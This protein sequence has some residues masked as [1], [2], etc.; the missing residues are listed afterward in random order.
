MVLGTWPSERY[1]LAWVTQRLMNRAPEQ[2]HARK[3]AAS[4]A[5]QLANPVG[6]EIQKTIQQL[7]EERDNMFVSSADISLID[8]IYKVD[9][10]PSCSFKFEENYKGEVVY[11]LPKVYAI[12]N[13]VEEEITIAKENDIQ[14]LIYEALPSRIEDGE[15]SYSHEK[16][17]PRTQV[18]DLVNITPKEMAIEGHL[19]ITLEENTNWE[20]R[21]NQKIY[22]S[23]VY[24]SGITRKGTEVTEVIP[25]RYN[26]TFRSTNQWKSVSEVFI[27]Y[28]DETAYLIVDCFPFAQ[29]GILDNRNLV[30]SPDREEKWRY[31]KL[32]TQAWGS[33]FVSEAYTTNNFDIIRQGIE[34][35]DTE[36]EIELLDS[37]GNN[38]SFDCFVMK[39]KTDYMFAVKDDKLYV[40]NTQLPYPEVT[41]LTDESPDVKMDLYS[42]QW[43]YCRADTAN[44]KTRLLDFAT[45]PWRVRWSIE[46]P[47]GTEYRLGRDGSLWDIDIEGW[48]DNTNWDEDSWMEQ[49]MKIDL[50]QSPLNQPGT[51]I[52]SLECMYIDE[53]LNNTKTLTTKFLFYLPSIQPEV[54]LDLPT[55]FTSITDIFFDSD[56]NLWTFINY[57]MYMIKVYYDYF[58]ADYSNNIIW[59]RE[60]Y[61]SVR[62]TV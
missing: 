36:Y 6:Q 56:G 7:L 60:H 35:R 25:V 44:I 27:S 16:V 40:Y 14:S 29:N 33:T 20:V 46:L 1:S 48:I 12:V 52:V 17:I 42:D 31:L 5:K 13:G 11:S 47:T 18:S 58:L 34:S 28:V 9:L 45:V 51:Y 24:I 22:Y 59:L 54:V 3:S 23:K 53:D 41:R 43:V 55:G 39:P 37:V 8:H 21:N 61:P 15:V 2:S 49:N 4:I 50:S 10:Q 57:D 32:G 30:V 62:I 19:Y 26:G 38:I